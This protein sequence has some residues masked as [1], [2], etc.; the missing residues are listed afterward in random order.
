MYKTKHKQ[1]NVAI[2]ATQY[3][4]LRASWKKFCKENG[5]I[6][7]NSY[8][9]SFVKPVQHTS[10]PLTPKVPVGNA[11]K[12]ERGTI[13]NV[14]NRDIKA[15]SLITSK[16]GTERSNHWH[17]TDWHFLYVLQGKMKYSE[18]S[19]DS[20]YVKVFIVEQGEMVFTKPGLVHKTEFLEDTVLMSLG[21][22]VDHD[23]D[24]VSE[25]Y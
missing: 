18:R 12:D 9:A 13:Q 23:A 25:K 22:Y 6:S 14:L 2:P 4:E 8:F 21:N 19:L 20:S 17:K 10:D 5:K 1:V 7:F 11:F 24:T 15:V 3:K 16:K